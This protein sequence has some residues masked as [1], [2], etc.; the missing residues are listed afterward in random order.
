[1]ARSHYRLLHT[2][3][4]KIASAEFIL[5]WKKYTV[6]F[7]TNSRKSRYQEALP[8]MLTY[9]CHLTIHSL[10]A[11]ISGFLA[12]LPFS[13]HH[14]VGVSNQNRHIKTVL[15]GTAC[16][17]EAKK[18]YRGRYSVTYHH[19]LG[20]LYQEN[21]KK[22]ST[23]LYTQLYSIVHRNC[24]SVL[25]SSRK[26]EITRV[27]LLFY[28]PSISTM[29]DTINCWGDEKDIWKTALLNALLFIIIRP[30]ALYCTGLKIGIVFIRLSDYQPPTEKSKYVDGGGGCLDGAAAFCA[31]SFFATTGSISCGSVP[32]QTFFKVLA[33]KGAEKD[34]EIN[35]NTYSN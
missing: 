11:F 6:Q 17:G 3:W 4:A 2:V 12:F 26:R 34:L 14:P 20:N 35:R 1:M 24:L 31:W 32:F 9:E 18:E 5:S 7:W 29:A 28:V 16:V 30:L 19:T 33:G 10:V 25:T 15:T 21:E 13:S 27:L 22:M 23:L 8:N